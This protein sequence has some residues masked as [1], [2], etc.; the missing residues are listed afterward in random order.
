MP[1]TS[2]INATCHETNIAIVI[3]TVTCIANES[4]AAACSKPFAARLASVA[5]ELAIDPTGWR[6]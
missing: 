1:T 2:E 3:Y 4:T 6:R 5:I